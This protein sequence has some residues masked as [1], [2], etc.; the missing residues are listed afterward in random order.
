LD[1]LVDG[2]LI[3]AQ[4]VGTGRFDLVVR[5]RCGYN[6]PTLKAAAVTGPKL[7]VAFVR[8]ASGLQAPVAVFVGKDIVVAH[9]MNIG[10][11]ELP[12][13]G[14]GP[15]GDAEVDAGSLAGNISL[16]VETVGG[17][18][19]RNDLVVAQRNRRISAR[20]YRRGSVGRVA[21]GLDA[22]VSLIDAQVADLEIVRERR[23]GAEGGRIAAYREVVGLASNCS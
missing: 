22:T 2:A 6:V 12:R 4:V 13:L 11:R 21:G 16:D 15:V 7:G 19:L 3:K 23:I 20:H 9:G 1:C 5:G 17:G 8:P 10:C 14:G 18:N